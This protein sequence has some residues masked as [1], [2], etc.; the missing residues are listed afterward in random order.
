MR[1]LKT[2]QTGNLDLHRVQQSTRDALA[3]LVAAQ[4]LGGRL[5]TDVALS[6]G[7]NDVPHGLGRAPF[8]YFVTKKAVG[9]EDATDGR[10]YARATRGAA[11]TIATGTVTVV[12]FDG[13][14]FDNRTAISGTG[15]T[16][17]RFTVPAGMAGIYQVSATLSLDTGAAATMGLRLYV[18]GAYVAELALLPAAANTNPVGLSGTTLV[19]LAAADYLDIRIVHAAGVDRDV[20][21]SAAANF[22]SIHRVCEST[23]TPTE[24]AGALDVWDAQDENPI[25]ELT[26]RLHASRAGTASLWVF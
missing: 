18:N 7:V 26:L 23:V 12:A 4:L 5:L 15:T 10:V 20:L 3:P 1:A 16:S 24:T 13:A 21:A 22:V 17:W 14:T 8:G 19:S 11:Q 2:F 6:E 25:P 9:P